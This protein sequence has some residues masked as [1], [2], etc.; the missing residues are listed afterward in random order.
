MI[1]T[2]S[3]YSF[4]IYGKEH[5]A[6]LERLKSL[7]VVHVRQNRNT[8]EIDEIKALLNKK[9]EVSDILTLSGMLLKA[10]AKSE[11]ELQVGEFEVPESGEDYVVAFRYTQNQIRQLSNKISANKEILSSLSVWG[12]FD[13]SIVE[14][15]RKDGLHL[16]FW[17]VPAASYNEL[18]EELYGAV[19]IGE[20]QR[21]FYFVTLHPEKLSSKD[22]PESDAVEVPKRSISDIEAEN[23]ALLSDLK[24]E[25]DKLVLLAQHTE[26]AKEYQLTLEETYRM[27][28]ARLQG[29]SLFDDQLIVLEGWL[30]KQKAQAMETALDKEGYAFAEL[31]IKEGE[32]VPIKLKN[33]FFARAFE[34]IIK[35]HSFPNYFEL[36]PTPF[37]APFFMLFF[38]MCFGDGGYGIILLIAAT[39]MKK[40]SAPDKKAM[41]TMLQY[42]GGATIII[43]FFMGTFFGV[44]YVNIPFL[45][46]FKAF[47]LSQ[48]NI[49]TI[50]IALGLVQIIFAKIIKAT[51]TTKQKGFKYSVSQFAW[52]FLILTG[53]LFFSLPLLKIELPQWVDYAVYG[54]LGL[55]GVFI[56]FFNSPGKNPLINVGSAIWTA[57]NTASGLL[58]DTLSYIRLFAIGLAGGILGGV[59]NDLALQVSGGLPIY[60]KWLPLI[61]ILTIGHGINFGLCLIG[62]FVHPIRLIFVEYF[63]N[64]DYEGGGV[65]YKP[66][67]KLKTEEAQ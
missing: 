12:D 28:D 59:F 55:F 25:Q 47:F 17:I 21:L 24:T 1:V 38:A 37:V 34:P 50:A 42:L 18:W 15:F 33:N 40:K 64:S 58:G 57:Y 41:M 5:E 16:Q 35:M 20:S 32:K 23:Q 45:A 27:D 61:I 22:L 52:A 39:L 46:P 7:G 14:K 9:K 36:D 4:L 60:I 3:K 67:Q 53:V 63:N 56:V 48:D 29:V 62:A 51:K 11:G 31:E 19:F 65:E 66:L 13:P 6:F 54:L 30:P 26:I 8:N 44:Q 49:M 43:S 10:H 2:M